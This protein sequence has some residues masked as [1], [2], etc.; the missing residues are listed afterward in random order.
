[1]DDLN[2]IL[3]LKQNLRP[4]MQRRLDLENQTDNLAEYIGGAKS[5][6]Y[7]LLSEAHYDSEVILHIYKTLYFLIVLHSCQNLL[8]EGTYTNN[9]RRFH[10]FYKCTE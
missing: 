3:L 4:H 2:K 10:R 1:M 7:Q 6:N 8:D 5:E 9:Q